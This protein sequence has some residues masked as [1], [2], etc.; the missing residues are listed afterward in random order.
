MKYYNRLS[1]VRNNGNGY[2]NMPNIPIPTDSDKYIIK[3]AFTLDAEN[4]TVDADEYVYGAGWANTRTAN[5]MSGN[6]LRVV[7]NSDGYIALYVAGNIM[8]GETRVLFPYKKGNMIFVYDCPDTLIAYVTAGKTITKYETTKTVTRDTSGTIIPSLYLLAYHRKF[9][10]AAGSV[11]TSVLYSSH[12]YLNYFQLALMN[13][14]K[15][16]ICAPVKL[17][18][19]TPRWVGL[20]GANNGGNT[21][22]IGIWCNSNTVENTPHASF[23]TSNATNT[24]SYGTTNKIVPQAQYYFEKYMD[25]YDTINEIVYTK[26]IQFCDTF[27]DTTC[28][29]LTKGIYQPYGSDGPDSYTAGHKKKSS[30]FSNKSIRYDDYLI[31]TQL[32]EDRYRKV[33]NQYTVVNMYLDGTTIKAKV[34]VIA[35]NVYVN[36]VKN[37]HNI[38]LMLVVEQK[39]MHNAFYHNT[40]TYNDAMWDCHGYDEVFSDIGHIYN[41]SSNFINRFVIPANF[42]DIEYSF[43]KIDDIPIPR[44]LRTIARSAKQFDGRWSSPVGLNDNELYIRYKIVLFDDTT[45]RYYPTLCKINTIYKQI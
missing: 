30:S 27:N 26:T 31:P 14:S 33:H 16:Y 20:Y 39:Y 42:Y 3:S 5:R 23:Y 10:N 40:K 24:V 38:Y 32:Y 25:Y 37:G 2:I 8:T 41:K 1:Y 28:P 11:S 43:L 12:I 19:H 22:Q 29:T 13:G 9:T 18:K 21:A 36:G 34:P 6:Y 4:M 7:K 44:T 45:Q 35:N 15:E 17:R